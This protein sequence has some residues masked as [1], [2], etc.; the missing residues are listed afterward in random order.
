MINTKMSVLGLANPEI[1]N[2]TSKKIKKYAI[3]SKI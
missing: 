1:R 2:S 3:G